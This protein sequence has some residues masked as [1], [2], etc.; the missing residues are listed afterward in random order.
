MGQS[1][2]S[3][4]FSQ[5]TGTSS[6]ITKRCWWRFI[7]AVDWKSW[8]KP[9]G[10]EL[11]HLPHL[12]SAQTSSEHIFFWCK[13]GKHFIRKCWR[14]FTRLMKKPLFDTILSEVQQH[15]QTKTSFSQLQTDIMAKVT[16]TTV[17]GQFYKFLDKQSTADDTWRFWKQFVLEDCFA[18]VCLFIAIRSGN[19]R[20]RV[21]SLKQ[22][23]PLFVTFD[24]PSY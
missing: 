19:W 14:L 8:Q 3:S 6:K 23:A 1:W 22:M 20:L 13:C 18:Y 4:W 5:V 12:K 21:S 16:D 11:R 2:T 7:R 9:Q 24:R 17:E 15:L 10:F